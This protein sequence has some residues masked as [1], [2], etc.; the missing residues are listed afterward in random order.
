VPVIVGIFTLNALL[1][2]PGSAVSI[3]RKAV[4]ESSYLFL[5]ILAALAFII[6]V[7]GDQL[8]MHRFFVPILPAMYLL[9]M[10]GLCEVFPREA[11]ESVFKI[12][13]KW[14]RAVGAMCLGGIILTCLPTFIGREHHR[15]FVVEK[16][17]DADRKIVGEWLR[18]NVGADTRIALVPAGIIPFYSGLETIDLVGLNDKHIA[19]SGAALGKGEPGHE[20]HDS[21]YV[22]GRRPDIMLLGA[23]RI[24][25]GRLAAEDLFDYYW[26]YGELVPGN[27]E[28]LM[29]REFRKNYVP[30]AVPVGGMGYLHFFKHKNFPMPLAEP[31][32][33][34]AVAS[35]R[36]SP[37]A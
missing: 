4:F 11:D 3:N 16:P 23:C 19:R 28:M 22:L 1:W 26:L 17:A 15:V 8:V 24:I 32:K 10:R 25:P 6:Y 2:R 30:C 14:R 37:T 20:K 33:S 29:L 7:G 34:K 36:V 13:R 5:Q 18:E 9:T 12:S 27:R 31:L 35:E 21:T